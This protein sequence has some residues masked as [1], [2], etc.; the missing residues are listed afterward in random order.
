LAA[1]TLIV[2]RSYLTLALASLFYAHWANSQTD[3]QNQ[4][5][6]PPAAAPPQQQDGQLPDEGN[7]P[8]EDETQKKPEYRFN[9]L[10]AK[11]ELDTG[12]FYMRKR[13]YRAAAARF[14]EA[15]RW[16]PSWAEAY[17]KLGEAQAKLKHSDDARRALAKVVELAPDSKEA[18]E[19]K[20]L[21]GQL[22][23]EKR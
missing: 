9:P 13:S 18:N 6:N 11:K 4:P 22:S 8:E 19:A 10:Q 1:Y 12:V 21:S 2:A 5:S 17:L 20:K 16:N 23:T 14:E 3:K 7:I 15:T